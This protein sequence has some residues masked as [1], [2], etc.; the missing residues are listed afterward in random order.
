MS[1]E[2]GTMSAGCDGLRL[3]VWRV[4]KLLAKLLGAVSREP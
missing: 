3:S 2:R 1:D 4:K